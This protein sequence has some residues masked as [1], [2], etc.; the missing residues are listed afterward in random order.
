[1]ARGTGIVDLC[2]DSTICTCTPCSC[3]MVL[4]IVYLFQNCPCLQLRFSNCCCPFLGMGLSL[5]PLPLLTASLGPTLHLEMAMFV[6]VMTLHIM[7]LL[8]L[9]VGT[10]GFILGPFLQ[11]P[12]YS[13]LVL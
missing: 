11:I 9:G 2:L 13:S 3:D 12:C 4:A 10:E 8:L 1:M 6:A 5:W 7:L